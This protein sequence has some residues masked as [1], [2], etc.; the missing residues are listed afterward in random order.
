M[1]D[2]SIESINEDYVV[3]LAR[4]HDADP[5]G[6]SADSEVY[7]ESDFSTVSFLGYDEDLPS[8]PKLDDKE[9]R[10]ILSDIV[11]RAIRQ[12]NKKRYLSFMEEARNRTAELFNLDPNDF[13]NGQMF[14]DEVRSRLRDEL[15]LRN[16]SPIGTI[17]RQLHKMA[18]PMNPNAVFMA[19]D[20]CDGYGFSAGK[21]D[22]RITAIENSVQ[23]RKDHAAG[24]CDDLGHKLNLD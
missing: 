23:F 17:H 10:A 14:D 19:K 8:T 1:D 20:L 21:D 9:K 22:R 16:D 2:E 7:A 5:Y 3:A 11:S 6:D 4:G 24:L 15:E 13:D 12:D 18:I